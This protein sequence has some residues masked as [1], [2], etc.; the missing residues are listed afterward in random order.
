[1]QK[2]KISLDKKLSSGDKKYFSLDIFLNISRTILII[3]GFF[4][5]GTYLI[6]YFE[7]RSSHKNQNF[8]DSTAKNLN[9]GENFIGIIDSGEVI[10][11]TLKRIEIELLNQEGINIPEVTKDK[12]VLIPNYTI[13]RKER[14][15]GPFNQGK[16]FITV[17]K[18]VESIALRKICDI[19][20]SENSEF[21][22]LI[23]CIYQD[24]EIGKQIALGALG[25]ESTKKQNE[26]WLAMYTYNPVEGDYF[27]DNPGGYI[28]EN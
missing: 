21:S 16:I 4:F 7:L 27:D 10:M 11:D 19:V 28:N 2:K 14:I 6:N 23:I 26:A 12:Q 1:M 13:E 17:N 24:N 20:A 8:G 5:L 9:V 22:N 15:S 3:F 18:D 25:Y